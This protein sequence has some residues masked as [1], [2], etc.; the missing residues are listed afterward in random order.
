MADYQTFETFLL[1]PDAPRRPLDWR[2]RR[3]LEL[4]TLPPRS[5]KGRSTDDDLILRY[6]DM[7]HRLSDYSSFEDFEKIRKKHPDLLEVHVAYATLNR[8]ELAIL[9]ALLLCR[10]ADTALVTGQ[11]GLTAEQQRAYRSVF[12]DVEDRRHMSLFIATQL[13]EPARLRGTGQDTLEARRAP[14]TPDRPRS[15]NGQGTLSCRTQCVLRVIG[16]YSGPVVLELLYTGFLSGTVPVGRD[17]SLQ[18]LSQ[19]HLTNIRRFGYF[20][21][22]EMPFQE[23][24]L[25]EVFKL[26]TSLA[27]EEREESQADIILHVDEA[28]KQF[29]PRIGSPVKILGEEK[30]PEGV[31]TGEYELRENDLVALTGAAK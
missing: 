24:G 6:A 23:D 5:R 3:A 30:L 15:W 28:F 19:A 26:A 16:F 27:R 9:D 22:G 29:R 12:L 2:Y 18:F 20:S 14:E 17:D 7:L 1:R 10:S 4:A 21:S 31:F 8:T 25:T 13:M 11:S